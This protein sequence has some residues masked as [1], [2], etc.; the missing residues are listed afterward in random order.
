MALVHLRMSKDGKNK[1]SFI[2][3]T[4][5]I[6]SVLC[7]GDINNHEFEVALMSGKVFDFNQLYYQGNFIFVHNMEQLYSLL[8][9]LDSGVI[10]DGS[11]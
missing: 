3:N 8:K 11:A 1:G 2:I 6:K 5:N 4:K 7:S 10:Q 9:K